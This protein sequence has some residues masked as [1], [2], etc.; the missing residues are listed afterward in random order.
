MG[1][2]QWRELER[3][4]RIGDDG[5]TLLTIGQMA[6]LNGVSE[7]ALRIYQAKGILEPARTDPATGYRSYTLGQCAALDMICQLRTVG[8][9]LDQIAEVLQA[10]DVATLRDRV[11]EHVEDVERQMRELSMAHQVAG[12][13][14]RSCEVY[15]DKP[16]CGQLI[17]ETIPERRV[18][19]FPLDRTQ[20]SDPA[21]SGC[22]AMGAWE[23]NLR[24]VKHE[25]VE[26]DLPVSLFRNVGCTIPRDD[27]LAGRILYRSAFVFVTP[28]FGSDIYEQATRVPACTHLV[29]YLDGV[30][31]DDGRERETVEIDRMLQECERRGLEPAGDYR[32]EVI[33]DGPAFMFEGRE[34]L[35]KMCLP[36]RLKDQ[37]SWQMPE[38]RDVMSA[39]REDRAENRAHTASRFHE[40]E[41]RG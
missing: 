17:L 27:L 28:A 6:R 31:T 13:L 18:L 36:V 9:S 35:F 39:W 8:F 40:G 14:L 1:Q 37:P 41:A 10:G 16:P 5:E 24:Y 30:L 21:A 32:G 20:S 11:R 19:E 26:R 23:F 3:S 25:I 12:D 15:L 7:K 4:A 22:D 38:Q 29:E 2:R 34:M 33:A